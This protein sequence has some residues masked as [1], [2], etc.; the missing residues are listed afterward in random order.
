MSYERFGCRLWSKSYNVCRQEGT[1]STVAELY[2]VRTLK[3]LEK[4]F[5]ALNSSDDHRQMF[6]SGRYTTAGIK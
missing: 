1:E 2:I 5:T 4:M 3:I 6:L